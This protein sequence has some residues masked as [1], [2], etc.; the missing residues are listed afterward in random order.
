M[1]K[2]WFLNDKRAVKWGIS[3]PF[4]IN[5]SFLIVFFFFFNL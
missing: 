2:I 4:N 3:S 5:D 1:V